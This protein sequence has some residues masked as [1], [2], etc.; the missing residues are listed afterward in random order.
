MNDLEALAEALKKV[1]ES[2]KY[3]Y[4]EPPGIEIVIAAAQE[5]LAQLDA[6]NQERKRK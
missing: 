1:V 3:S 2:F 5:R 6:L 4:A